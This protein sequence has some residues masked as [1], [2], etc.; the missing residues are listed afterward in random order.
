MDEILGDERIS[1]GAPVAQGRVQVQDGQPA[2]DGDSLHHA[3][4]NRQ[5]IVDS[6]HV[7]LRDDLM[8]T[9]QTA[10]ASAGIP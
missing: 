2:R 9:G 8:N 4:A 3:S 6:G 10:S 5:G 7:G 1:S